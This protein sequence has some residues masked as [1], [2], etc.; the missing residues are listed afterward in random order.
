MVDAPSLG[1]TAAAISRCTYLMALSNTGQSACCS[2]RCVTSSPGAP[3]SNRSTS[4][5]DWLWVS[6][7]GQRHD[8]S[9]WAELVWE[10]ELCL[11][12]VLLLLRHACVTM[13]HGRQWKTRNAFFYREGMVAGTTFEVPVFQF[14]LCRFDP[15]AALLLCCCCCCAV[16]LL[17]CLLYC[18]AAVLPA[19]LCWCF[20]ACAVPLFVPICGWPFFIV[21]SS[22]SSSHRPFITSYYTHTLFWCSLCSAVFFSCCCVFLSF[23][24]ASE[25]L[26]FSFDFSIRINCWSWVAWVVSRGECFHIPGTSTLSCTRYKIT[27]GRMWSRSV[28][29]A[30]RWWCRWRTGGV[31]AGER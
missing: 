4:P 10:I 15:A 23:V 5:V 30:P 8:Q 17:C 2:S 25:L 16:L 1:R 26:S 20:A 7:N 29:L 9:L 6:S 22:R 12:L 24:V 21:G 28:R 31:I 11:P 14:F 27:A 13:T 3:L 19:V 18:A